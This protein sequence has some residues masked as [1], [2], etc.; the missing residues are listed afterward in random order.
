MN[1]CQGLLTVVG[2]IEGGAPY[3][4]LTAR[5]VTPEDRAGTRPRS[6][7]EATSAVDL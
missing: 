5:K 2:L 7:N 3:P 6:C 4:G 1:S